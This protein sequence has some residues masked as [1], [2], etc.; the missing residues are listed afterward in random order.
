VL[1]RALSLEY[2]GVIQYLQDAFLVQGPYREVH[3][4]FFKGMSEGAWKDAGKL[5]QWV[6]LLNGIPTLEPAPIKQSTDLTE[7]LRQGLELER[8]AHKIYLEALTVVSEDPALRLFVEA[9]V[10]DH[11][12]HIDQFEKLLGQKTLAVA[13]KEVKLRP[14]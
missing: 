11:R 4:N 7:M 12:L 9:M 3:E 1:N 2:A 10:Q 13:T 6:V 14:A 5:G 8:E